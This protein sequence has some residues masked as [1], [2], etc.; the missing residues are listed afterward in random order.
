VFSRV[1]STILEFQL[2]ISRNAT[3]AQKGDAPIDEMHYVDSSP[4]ARVFGGC[5]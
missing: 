3:K 4:E 2:A 1:P 5:N